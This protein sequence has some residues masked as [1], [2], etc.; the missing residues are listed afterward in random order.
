MSKTEYSHTLDR[1]GGGGLDMRWNDAVP[2]YA[3]FNVEIMVQLISKNVAILS[4]VHKKVM[5]V[6]SRTIVYNEMRTLNYLI[7]NRTSQ[8]KK[9]R[10]K[11][12]SV[13]P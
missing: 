8:L 1:E 11:K 5:H 4:T 9:C 7:L 10:L 3:R 6:L 12:K 2:L 13:Q